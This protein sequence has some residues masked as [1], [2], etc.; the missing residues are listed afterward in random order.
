MPIYEYI[1]LDCE[2]RFETLVLSSE[3]EVACPS[4]ESKRLEKVMSAFSL[5]G[6]GREAGGCSATGGFS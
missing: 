6:G 5:A 3:E 2:N 1:C 4:C